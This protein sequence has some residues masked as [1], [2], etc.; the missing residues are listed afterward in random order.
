[1]KQVLPLGGERS[2]SSQLSVSLGQTPPLKKLTDFICNMLSYTQYLGNLNSLLSPSAIIEY[3]DND[4]EN[5]RN[6][7]RKEFGLSQKKK[8]LLP[9]AFKKSLN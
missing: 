6:D 1:M 2:I 9:K 5:Y 4:K 8:L 7:Q 3:N